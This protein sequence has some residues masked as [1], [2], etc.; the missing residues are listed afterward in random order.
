MAIAHWIRVG[1]VPGVWGL[2]GDGVARS[3]AGAM[4]VEASLARGIGMLATIAVSEGI[5]RR[6]RK[7]YAG[8]TATGWQS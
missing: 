5:R 6:I 3:L 4:G 7:Q 8:S 1:L 2:I